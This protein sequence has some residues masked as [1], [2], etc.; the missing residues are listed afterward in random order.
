MF[1]NSFATIFLLL[2]AALIIAMPRRW[3]SLP[4]L[5][6]AC[7]MTLAQGVILGPFHFTVIR[8]LVAVALVRVFIRGERLTG[9]LNLLDWTMLTWACWALISS[10]FHK[11]PSSELVFHLGLVYDACGMYFLLRVF[12]QSLDDVAALCRVTAFLLVPV[13]AEMVF[14]RLMGYNLFSIL[15]GLPEIPDIRDGKIRAQGPFQHAIL[16]GTV[17][18]VC[19][20]LMMGLRQRYR[21]EAATGIIA[22]TTMV[23]T[24]VSSGPIMSALMGIGALFMWRFRRN[25]RLVRWAAI[26]GYIA[27]DLVMQS[28]AYYILARIDLTGGSTGWHRAALIES[29]LVHLGE[30]WIGGTDYTRHW[31]PTGIAWSADHTDITNYY[32]KMGVIG[33]LPLTILLVM[34]LVRGFSFVGQAVR[35][36]VD[37]SLDYRFMLWAL[38]ASLFA[39]TATMISVSYFDQSFVFLYLTLAMIGSTASTKVPSGAH[40]KN[41][42]AS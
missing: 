20:P 2:N 31:L 36:R 24:S 41:W 1:L 40:P 29:A 22:C 7:Y 13:A 19:L 33:G 3:A 16:A 23:F 37:L 42:S 25:M 8:I 28:P 34:L 26:L 39:H 18:A 9:G 21:K 14:E 12:S 38:G 32:I 4:L 30:W 15:G 35:E 6:G 17:G 10:A 27:L 11:D 5:V